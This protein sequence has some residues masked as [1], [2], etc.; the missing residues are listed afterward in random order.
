MQEI[1][2]IIGEI[3]AKKLAPVHTHGSRDSPKH[4]TEVCGHFFAH[5]RPI[6]R[7]TGKWSIFAEGKNRRS[8]KR[9]ED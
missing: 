9:E 7:R 1:F 5:T 4:V 8:G 2:E 3:D 6:C